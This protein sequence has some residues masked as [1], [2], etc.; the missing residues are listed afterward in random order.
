[1]DEGNRIQDHIK[2]IRFCQSCHVDVRVRLLGDEG[3]E[4][5]RVDELILSRNADVGGYRQAL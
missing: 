2:V 4:T 3:D 5:I 1:M